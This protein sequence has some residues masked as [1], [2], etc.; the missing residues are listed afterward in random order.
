V[1]GRYF[2]NKSLALLDP[3]AND[4]ETLGKAIPLLADKARP[5]GRPAA[6]VCENYTCKEPVFDADA[7]D[8]ALG[9]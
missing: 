3:A 8:K 4:P 1:H 9:G 2:P 6:Y 7:L 5:D